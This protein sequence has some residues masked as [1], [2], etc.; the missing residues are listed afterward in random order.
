LSLQ[1]RY[2]SFFQLVSPLF[3]SSASSSSSS[4]SSSTTTSE[5]Y[6]CIHNKYNMITSSANRG[7]YIS[8]LTRLPSS[9][10]VALYIHQFMLKLVELKPK[11]A[12]IK[13]F[14]SSSS[15]FSLLYSRC[16]IMLM[17]TYHIFFVIWVSAHGIE[18]ENDVRA[19]R[20]MVLCG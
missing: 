7:D 5:R 6:K 15:S 2:L 13:T 20:L 17:R 10:C 8:K 4:L 19:I 11:F 12:Y 14:F 1:L 3:N 18:T 9:I 16:L